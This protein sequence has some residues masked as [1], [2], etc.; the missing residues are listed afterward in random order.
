MA[1]Q[2]TPLI[3]VGIRKAA[4]WVAEA[5]V[6]QRAGHLVSKYLGSGIAQGANQ[7]HQEP[8]LSAAAAAKT[9]AGAA[10][11]I[12]PGRIAGNIGKEV[13]ADATK[14]IEKV[15]GNGA[16]VFKASLET[17][18]AV[19][20]TLSM[21]NAVAETAPGVKPPAPSRTRNAMPM[22]GMG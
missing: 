20:A 9:V 2:L 10:A 17:L 16:T 7:R 1:I 19:T 5:A 4:L 15:A 22:P 18:N 12:A 6:M 14:K 21:G 11:G 3:G 8:H 13:T